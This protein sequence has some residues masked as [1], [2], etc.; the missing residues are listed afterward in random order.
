MIVREV[1]GVQMVNCLAGGL[2]PV[3]PPVQLEAMGFKLAAYPLDLLNASVV[4]MRLALKGLASGKPP[5]ELTLPFAELQKI[6]G[7][8]EYYDEEARYRVP[9]DRPGPDR[10]ESDPQEAR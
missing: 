2:T 5:D 7:F 3:L 9:E 1:G 8:P 10:N 6:V 4:G